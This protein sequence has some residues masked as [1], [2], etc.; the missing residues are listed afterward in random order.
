MNPKDQPPPAGR[1]IREV[2]LLV[3]VGMLSILVVVA[4]TLNIFIH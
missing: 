4:V 1:V 3:L 2:G